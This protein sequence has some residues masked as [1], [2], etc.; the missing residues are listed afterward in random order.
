METTGTGRSRM[1]RKEFIGGVSITAA[2]LLASNAVSPWAAQAQGDREAAATARLSQFCRGD[3]SDESGKIQTVFD[4]YSN[5]LVDA[6]PGGVGYGIG[7]AGVRIPSGR[8]IY[9]TSASQPGRFVRA[10]R[11]Q[12]GQVMFR[13]SDYTAGNNNI[14]MRDLVIEGRRNTDPSVPDR[15]SD[16]DTTCMRFKV[17]A[18]GGERLRYVTLERVKVLNWPGIGISTL[19][20]KHF[21]YTDVQNINSARGGIRFT[22]SCYDIRLTRCISRD[23]GDTSFGFWTTNFVFDDPTSGNITGDLYNIVL[24]NCRGGTRSN[25]QYGAGLMIWGARRVTARGCTFSNAKND[26]VHIHDD[27]ESRIKYWIP[28][29]ILIEDCRI[30]GGRSNSLQVLAD[31]AENI[32]VRSNYMERPARNCVSVQP[33]TQ[34]KPHTLDVSIF[35]NTLVNPGLLHIRVD[36][37]V[38]GVKIRGNIQR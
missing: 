15:D 24:T 19:N 3:G 9:G 38:R 22:A 33:V 34:N 25:S 18:T 29:N 20:G 12:K 8:L 23:T 31:R 30:Y 6:P 26:V 7:P 4:R 10:G 37:D 17:E 36:D 16:N 32:M 28:Q 1:S 13:N 35:N 14:R 21:Y 11:F 27:R 2:A 5:V